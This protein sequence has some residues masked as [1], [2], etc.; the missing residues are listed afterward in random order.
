M[1]V[2]RLRLDSECWIV[3][4]FDRFTW[5]S[6][7]M[8]L[9]KRMIQLETTMIRDVYPQRGFDRHVLL[10]NPRLGNTVAK[11]DCNK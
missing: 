1:D 2:C 7:V 6:T 4:Y 11:A 5:G 3:C 10:C 9:T 8:C